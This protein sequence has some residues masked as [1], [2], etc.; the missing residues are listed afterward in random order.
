[1]T[2]TQVATLS[3]FPVSIALPVQWG[4]QDMFG[5]VN[6]TVYFRWFESARIAYLE[7]IGLS[8]LMTKQRVGPILAAIGCNYRKQLTYPDM[9]DVGAMVVKLGRTSVTM[10]HALFSRRQ[11]ALIADGQSTIVVFD[12]E[13]QRPMP[14]PAE[15][16]AA[17]EKIEGAI[18]KDSSNSPRDSSV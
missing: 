1:M 4:D 8:D 16:R 13:T 17:I 10:V 9:V 11:Q 3:E 12:Y 15:I 18:G 7:R 5:H 2:D 14:V 6:N